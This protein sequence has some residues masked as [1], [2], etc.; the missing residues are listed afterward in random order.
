MS[1]YYFGCL[2]YR[3]RQPF[4]TYLHLSPITTEQRGLRIHLSCESA[5]LV[6]TK[7][8]CSGTHCNPNPWE[9]AV[10]NSEVQGHSWLHNEFETTAG[11]NQPYLKS[12]IR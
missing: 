7:P 5:C 11:H 10:G 9:V 1:V 12:E 3:E 8:G 2:C 6:C 4:L